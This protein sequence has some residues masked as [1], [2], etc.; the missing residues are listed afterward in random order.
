[1]NEE[2]WHP[3]DDWE[4]EPEDE[5]KE[6]VRNSNTRVSDKKVVKRNPKMHKNLKSLHRAG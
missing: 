1:M 3:V 2:Q 6:T 5:H 4:T